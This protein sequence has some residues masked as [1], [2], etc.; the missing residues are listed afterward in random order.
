MQLKQ[1]RYYIEQY[2]QYLN[3]RQNDIHLHIWES[4]RIF[5]EVWDDEA[6]DWG[7][8][9]DRA[10]QNSTTKRLWLR[11]AY[12]PKAMM[13]KLIAF[14]PDFARNMFEDLFNEDKQL[15]GR[16]SRFTF[17]CDTLL[18]AYRE[19]YPLKI[20]NSHYH[21][22]DYHMVFLYLAFRYPQRYTL[23]DATAFRQLLQTLGSH[24]IPKVNDVE[25]FTKVVHTLHKFLRKEE[26]LIT[27]HQR[28]LQEEI[29][30]LD[31]SLLLVYDFYQFVVRN[32]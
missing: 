26:A 22:D 18:E 28:R 16:V 27:A 9:Y 14:Q 25:R 32:T 5:Q 1:L 15:E 2:H 29:H 11:E 12:E 7:N 8:M 21:H 6:T 4:Q 10:L 13:Q 30:Y 3:T 24:D 19:E 17:Y 31:D 23:Y 20:D